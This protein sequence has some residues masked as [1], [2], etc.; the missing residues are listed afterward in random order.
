MQIEEFLQVERSLGHSTPTD[1]QMD[2]DV[3]NI[4]LCC[5]PIDHNI[6]LQPRLAS[7]VPDLV[8][9]LHWTNWSRQEHLG[10]SACLFR[11]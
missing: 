10:A 11:R 2:A 7:L 3:N 8:A 4:F 6:H 1:D 9:R 5:S